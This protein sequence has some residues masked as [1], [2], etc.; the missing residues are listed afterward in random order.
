[1]PI[2]PIDSGRYGTKEMKDIFEEDRKLNYEL[3]FES[4]VA[5]AQAELQIIPMEASKNI[6][7]VI[8]SNKITVQRVKELESISD[9]DTA[10]IVEAIS[11]LCSESSKPWIHYGLTSNDVVDSSTS[12]QMRDVFKILESKLHQ[13]I[14]EL[15]KKSTEYQDLPAVGR[16]HGQ[17]ASITSFG[18]KFAIWSNELLDHLIRIDEGK[19]RF[20]LCKTL[21]VVGTGSLMRENA[22]E[23]E[24]IVAKKLDLYPVEAATQ[25]I[26]RE[27]YSEMLFTITLIALT[28]D[29]IAIEIR[30]LQRTEIGEVQEPFKKGQMGS[31]AVPVKKNP[32]KSERISSLARIVK[33]DLNVSLENIALWH[34]RDLSNSANERFIIPMSSILVDDMITTMIKIIAGLKINKEKIINNIELTRGQIFAEFVLQVLVLKGIPRFKAYRDIQSIAFNAVEKQEHFFDALI[35]EEEIIKNVS[36]E[37]LEVIFNPQSQLSASKNIIRNI[38]NKAKQM[39]IS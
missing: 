31:S 20:L 7:E 27:R 10:A 16:T 2:L 3:I 33:S 13:L 19:K 21:G 38:V 26:P 4:A 28:L 32:I 8:S 30:N 24:K 1:M 29:K 17:H 18:L 36:K 6:E 35:K 37:E 39:N 22:L 25:V 15:L 12:M 23:V 9:H 5:N 14:N 11:E 34:E